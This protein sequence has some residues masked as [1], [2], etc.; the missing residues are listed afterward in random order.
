MVGSVRVRC[1]QIGGECECA[2][3]YESDQGSS[4]DAPRRL[5]IRRVGD[6]IARLELPNGMPHAAITSAYR[7]LPKPIRLK[8]RGLPSAVSAVAK[9]EHAHDLSHR[10]RL[11]TY[12]CFGAAGTVGVE[13][14]V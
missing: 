1:L 12:Y 10:A 4:Q 5:R 8:R 3:T 2:G 7:T 9:S 6:P 11:R 14:T 13:G